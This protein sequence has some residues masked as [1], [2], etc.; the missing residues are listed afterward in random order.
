MV[1]HDDERLYDDRESSYPANPRTHSYQYQHRDTVD[2]YYYDNHNP[3]ESAD[4]GIRDDASIQ[5][6]REDEAASSGFNNVELP[7]WQNRAR[8]TVS[9]AGGREEPA[10]CQELGRHIAGGQVAIYRLRIK[11]PLML[12]KACYASSE[13]RATRLPTLELET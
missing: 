5:D 11:R 7:E 2:D 12:S 6:Y 1:N 10:S 8:N 4:I 9:T 3:Q 13:E